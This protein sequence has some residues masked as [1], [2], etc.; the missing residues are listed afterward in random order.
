MA[1]LEWFGALL[2]RLFSF[3]FKKS[4]SG[5]NVSQKTSIKQSIKGNQ[6]KIENNINRNK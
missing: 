1:I 5:T 4:T 2:P 6:N 3:L